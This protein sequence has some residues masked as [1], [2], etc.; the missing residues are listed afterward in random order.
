MRRFF[1]V[2][3][4]LFSLPALAANLT[5][6]QVSNWLDSYQPLTSF[7]RAHGKEIQKASQPG[8]QGLTDEAL[9][10]SGTYKPFYALLNKYGFEDARAWQQTSKDVYMAY[11]ASKLEGKNPKIDERIEKVQNDDSMSE[12]QKKAMLQML[13]AT[14]NMYAKAKQVPQANVKV[15]KAHMKELDALSNA[16]APKAPKAAD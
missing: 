15:V 13:N 7:M 10:K 2:L 1:I 8:Q 14:K 9:K 5:D 11:M 6:K 12:Q 3:C 4:C 16:A